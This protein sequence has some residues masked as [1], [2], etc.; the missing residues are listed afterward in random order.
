MIYKVLGGSSKDALNGTI[1]AQTIALQNG[2][3]ILRVHD[4]SEAIE[5]IKITNFGNMQAG[6]IVNLE[7]DIIG[8]YLR[9]MNSVNH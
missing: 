9:K 3:D 6:T 8:K 2:A 5:C 1:I 7:F 4:V